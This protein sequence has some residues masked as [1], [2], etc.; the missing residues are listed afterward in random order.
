MLALIYLGL[1]I[2]L[3]DCL[4]CRFYRFVSIA[5]RWAAGAL[6]GL[7]LSS[8]FTYLSARLLARTA[9]PLLWADLLFFVGAAAAL[10]LLKRRPIPPLTEPRAPGSERWDWVTLAIY[11]ALACW[12]MFATLNAKDGV[13]QIGNNEWSDFGPNTAIIRSFSVGHNFPT[14]YP[15]FSGRPIRYHFLFYFQAG[16]LEFLGLNLAWSLNLLSILSLVCMLALVMA[17]AQL[18]FNSRAV[19]RI[20]S[21]LFFFHGSLSFFPFLRS[22]TSLAAALHSIH[23]LRDFLPS[24]YPY[25]GEL[26]GVWSQVV[27]LNQRHLA[28]GIG[29]FLVVLIF[30]VDRYREKARAPVV[31]GDEA[32]PSVTT[33]AL[34]LPAIALGEAI[35]GH[36]T[37]ADSASPETAEPSVGVATKVSNALKDVFVSGRSFFFSGV[38]LGALPFWNALVFTSAAAVLFLL[39]VLFPYR[40]YMIGMA[41]TAG[42]VAFPQI[43]FLRA[44]NLKATHSLLHWGYII[45]DPTLGKV[46]KYLGFTFGAKWLLLGLA[47]LF[48]SWFHRRFFLA[49]CSLLL[50]TFCFQFSEEALA[51]HKFLNIW[52]IVANMFVAYAFWLLWHAK[53]RGLVI[54]ARLT[55][56][57]LAIPIVVGGVIDLFPIHNSYYMEM[58][59]KND[60][61]LDWV[62]SHTKPDDIFLSD[63]FVNHSILLAGRKVFYGWPSFAWSAGYNVIK[64]DDTY[65][66][67]FESTDPRQ[68]FR[69]LHEN[70]ISYVAID[71]GVR[72]GEFIKQANEEFYADNFQKVWEDKGNKYASLVIYKVPAVVPT[73]FK[74]PDPARPKVPVVEP[75]PVT[76]FQGGKGTGRGQF[77]FPRG[78]AVDATGNILVADT[79]NGRIQK[80]SS[81][82]QF[83]ATIGRPG[84]GDGEFQEPNS[85]AFDSAGNLYVADV[86]NQ[87]VQKLTATGFFL[88]QWKGPDPGFYGPRDIWIS[89]DNFIYV[90]DQGHSRI[91]KLDSSGI[92][93]AVW[94]SAGQGDG[95][96]AEPTAVAVDQQGDRVYVADRRNKRIQVFDTNGKFITKWPVE[97]WQATG[98]AFQDLL[99]DSKTQRLYATSPTTD[100]VLVFDLAGKRLGALKPKPPDKLEGAS[101]LAI[102]NRALYVLCTFGNRVIQIDLDA[103]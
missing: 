89:P 32:L 39:F 40:K 31:P 101:G 27:F 13:L 100:E 16:N 96:F 87:R 6:V 12:M 1:A 77:D 82:G 99:V 84:R 85:I 103:K 8:W 7:L 28:S 61:L 55:A 66:Q 21:A 17:L 83:L 78:I 79:N 76:M 44:G 71:N 51:N 59:Y 36:A 48:V 19:G 38:L 75:P 43:R 88:T 72:R 18:L 37:A 47:L 10:F 81:T 4:C 102:L 29:I 70:H 67:L 33:H 20:A 34:D 11:L 9:R 58:R 74:L 22:Q 14:Q 62:Q 86:S 49:F 15:H 26:W 91:V 90:V 65:R 24:G 69:L 80:F 63:R 56:I 46:I 64:R 45:D 68:V 35:V 5:H 30:L 93:R 60:P 23:T 42:L 92:A 97:E 95:Q 41:L 54:A 94:G 98:W 3:G 50:L 73:T 57:V 53:I 2:Y 25:R 52:L